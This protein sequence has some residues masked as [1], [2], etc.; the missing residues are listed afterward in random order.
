M[1]WDW[2]KSEAWL[3]NAGHFLA[4]LSVLMVTTVF[5]HSWL[6]IGIVEAVLALYVGVKEFW[7]D[8]RYESNE[9]YASGTIDA[10]GYVA[11]NSVGWLM[12]AAAHAVGSW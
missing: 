5:T 1:N 4:G 10:L 3:A 2:M 11:G 6:A 8:I 9:D 7:F 12:L